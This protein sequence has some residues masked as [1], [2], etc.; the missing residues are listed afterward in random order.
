MRKHIFQ[1]AYLTTKGENI[2]I[3]FDVY[4]DKLVFVGT[5]TTHYK[6]ES[7]VTKIIP[8]FII[9][10]SFT[11]DNG[12][13]IKINSIGEEIFGSR[14]ITSKDGLFPIN[15]E[16]DIYFET[17]VISDEISYIE[18]GAF[19]FS[20]VGTVIWPA[21]CHRIKDSTFF[22][23]SIKQIKGIDL[24]TII[25]PRAFDDS[26]LERITYPSEC[27]IIPNYCFLNC[28][29]LTEIKGI[30]KIYEIGAYAFSGTGIEE[31]TIPLR[32]E[33]IEENCFLNCSKLEKIEMA[34]VKTIKRQAFKNCCNLKTI[35]WPKKSNCIPP[36]CFSGCAHLK[37]ITISGPLFIIST[38]AIIYTSVD[39][40]DISS[41]FTPHLKISD[42]NDKFD[43]I[44]SV[45]Q[46]YSYY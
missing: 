32:C 38:K 15:I 31:L 37:E 26:G 40:I 14:V 17:M 23:S 9:P 18:D 19:V 41:S 12:E 35:N 10:S 20:S 5:S 25:E 1:K 42:I 36:E 39:K 16:S 30:D 46:S 22:K 6:S 11:T 33:I 27:Y 4:D 29:N 8:E 45:Y 34:N 28:K 2:Q 13:T 24:V 21:H 3:F 44:S 7:E 43:V